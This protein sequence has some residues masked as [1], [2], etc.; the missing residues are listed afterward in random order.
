M[1]IEVKYRNLKK[2]VGVKYR[3]AKRKVGYFLRNNEEKI[4]KAIVVVSTIVVPAA[5]KVMS[6]AH[7]VRCENEKRDMAYRIWDP[8]RRCYHYATRKLSSYDREYIARRHFE[9][10]EGYED[11]LRSMHILKY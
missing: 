2:T 11:I 5:C 8:S 10:H 3:N 9:N 1:S 4:V 6:T 7:H